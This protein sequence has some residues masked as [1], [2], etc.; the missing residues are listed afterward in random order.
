M[1]GVQALRHR[2]R[3]HFERFPAHCRL[4]G[5]EVEMLDRPHPYQRF[6]LRGDLPLE[7]L[8]ERRFFP[9]YPTPGQIERC[10]SAR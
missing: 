6:D 3:R 2:V 5:L 9:A 10:K 8:G 7:L 1:V 4:D